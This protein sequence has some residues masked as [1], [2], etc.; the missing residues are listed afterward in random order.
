MQLLLAVGMLL[1]SILVANGQQDFTSLEE[2]ATAIKEGSMHFTLRSNSSAF[3]RD[4]QTH[5]S[6]EM[7]AMREVS[8]GMFAHVY[9]QALSVVP[10]IQQ[11]D[12]DAMYLSISNGV[13]ECV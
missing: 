7:Q 13:G 3:Y 10:M 9:V 6:E 2:L 5:I 11:P 8:G 1:S 12:Q 4:I